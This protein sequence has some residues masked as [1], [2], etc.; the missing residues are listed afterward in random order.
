MPFLSILFDLIPAGFQKET[1]HAPACFGDLNLDQ[2]VDAIVVGKQEYN[3]KPFYYT[4]LPNVDSIVYRQATFQDLEDA[5]L[6]GRVQAFAQEMVIVRRY[7][8]MLAK[9]DFKYHRQ[10]WFLEAAGVY[11]AAV[12]RLAQDL[13]QVQLTSP[14]LIDFTGYLAS[15]TRSNDFTSL[16]AEIQALKTALAS[17]KYSVIVKPGAVRVR[18]YEEET[19][20]SVEVLDTF[21]KFKQGAVK[22]Y[23]I[24]LPEGS[25]M[26]HVEGQILNFVAKL[27]PEI[28]ASLEEFYTRRNQFLP[29]TIR[30]FDREIQFYVAYLEYLA[31]FKSVGLK[32]CYPQISAQTKVELESEGFDLA[33]ATKCVHEYRPIVT[34]D[35]YLNDPERIFVVSGPNQG[36]KTTFARMFGQLH[37]LASLGCP[38]P[39]K[40]ARLFLCDQ[41]FTHFEKEENIRNLR[42]KLQDDL[43][44]VSEILAQATPDS[45][46]IMN[47]IFT[48]TTLKDAVYLSKKIIAQVIQLDLLCVY[49]T[50]LDELATLSEKTVSLV[51]TV[52]PENPAIRTFK[53]LRQPADGLAYALSVAEKYRLTYAS[54]KERI[55]S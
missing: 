16:Q 35:F 9:L 1:P 29:E 21:E 52:S 20:Y 26:N 14:G 12:S 43:V 36:G 23:R 49:V 45:I 30:V 11:T 19:D 37:Y 7:L 17:V 34:N 54:L 6:L 13:S 46:V 41:I 51:S 38:V 39:G 8:A 28:F 53:V 2:I 24:K 44:R 3:L 10:G 42:G 15:Y 31:R 48:S 4:P 50:F 47:E 27:Y 33:L 5:G 40:E 22:D 55:Q 25:G 32:F 18:K